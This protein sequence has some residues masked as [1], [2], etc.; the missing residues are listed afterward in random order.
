[1]DANG[2]EWT[3]MDANKVKKQQNTLFSCQDFGT[4][5]S[6]SAI[7][8]EPTLYHGGDSRVFASIRG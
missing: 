4:R 3:R 8:N 1:M 6:L 2:R 7:R 5:A